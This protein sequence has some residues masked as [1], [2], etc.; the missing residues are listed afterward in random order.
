MLD[1]LQKIFSL[2]T[3]M[4]RKQ[5]CWIFVAMLG[6]ALLDVVGV[7]SIM[8]FMAVVSNAN[9]LEEHAKIYA[10]YQA[11]PFNNVR[12]FLLFLGFIVLGI[13]LLGN[14]YTIMTTWLMTRF[15]TMREFTLSKRL[16]EKYLSQPYTFFLQ[17]NTANLNSNIF[18]QISAVVM[19]MLMP[20]L[21]VIAKLIVVVLMLSLLFYVNFLLALTS[22]V[23]LG[24]A[25]AAIYLLARRKLARLGEAYVK[26]NQERFKIA[27]EAL[28]GIKDIK[29]LHCE[30]TFLNRYTKP[31]RQL[32]EHN[33]ISS[34]MGVIPRYALET[35]AFSGVLLIVIYFLFMQKNIND[36]MPMLALY[37]FACFRLM[38]ALQQIFAGL[39]S[40][41]SHQA[42]LAE[43][44]QDLQTTEALIATQSTNKIFHF[45]ETLQLKNVSFSYHAAQAEVIKNLS[46]TIPIKSTVGFVGA[47]GSGKTTTVDLILG[48]LRPHA[49]QLLVDGIEINDSHLPA[50]QKKL[51]YVAQAIYLADDTITNNIAFGVPP[52]KIDHLAVQRAAIMANIH[53]FI[54]HDLPRGYDTLIGERG[55]RL[56]GGQCQRIGIARALYHDPEVL[57]L[58]EATSALDGITENAIMDAVHSLAHQ[59]TIII[60]AHRIAT[61]KA[62]DAIYLFDKGKIV[63]A[64]SY[65]VL[66]ASDTSFRKLAHLS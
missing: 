43:I 56:S 2:L 26:N 41:Q 60:I 55:V 58:D 38:P 9:H 61:V 50:W 24:G 30:Q 42:A 40:M 5:A 20:A 65:D 15:A 57:V 4:E 3:P 12:C 53:E 34:T 7:A 27:N 37:A 23:F 52:E 1:S 13:L 49:G 33:A 59:K 32:A 8:P 44:Y 25:Y 16:L 62:C 19:G 21:Q 29:L 66:L 47:T 18:S 54:S 45:T 36:I 17:Q 63:Q 46:L 48:L 39:T 6:M 31:A 22:M 10:L 64:G 35:I 28:G 11:L 51:G 14:S